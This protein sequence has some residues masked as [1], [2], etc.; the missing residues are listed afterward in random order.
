M[1]R[2]SQE[3][4]FSMVWCVGK[5]NIE[6]S[7]ILNAR[8]K[9]NIKKRITTVSRT[10]LLWKGHN[11]VGWIKYFLRVLL[12]QHYYFLSKVIYA[13]SMCYLPQPP[14]WKLAYSQSYLLQYTSIEKVYLWYDDVILAALSS[15]YQSVPIC[16]T[17]EF[18]CLKP[19]NLLYSLLFALEF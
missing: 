17:C 12:I 11:K 9:I 1:K 7:Q 2:N 4:L 5:N 14:R 19:C 10:G 16:Q 8:N 6:L 3:K 18:Y 13:F 15:E